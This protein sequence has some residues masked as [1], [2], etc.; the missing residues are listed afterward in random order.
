MTPNNDPSI[1]ISD[2]YVSNDNLTFTVSSANGGNAI[3]TVTLKSDNYADVTLTIP[4]K[5]QDKVTEVKLDPGSGVNSSVQGVEVKGLSE[6]TQNQNTPSGQPVKVMLEMKPVSEPVNASGQTAYQIKT[7][8]DNKVT[9]I[10]NTVNS[11]NT[12]NTKTEYL[13]IKVSKKVGSGSEETIGDVERVLEIAVKYDLT[14]KFNPVVIREHEGAVTAFTAL[15]NRPQEGYRDGTFYIDEDLGII[16]IYSRYFSTFSVA[17]ATVNSFPVTL[18]ANGGTMNLDSQNIVVAEGSMLTLPRP[19]R[20]G[21]DFNGWKEDTN[22]TYQANAS[23]TIAKAT[24]FIVQW[25]PIS[26]GGGSSIPT[27]GGSSYSAPATRDLLPAGG[28]FTFPKPTQR[29]R[30]RNTGNRCI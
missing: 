26:S 23:V 11:G 2:F 28:S 14:G 16:Y 1:G 6:Y 12:N 19:T 15:S 10:F 24:T 13:D 8:I 21:Y 27:G 5:V 30:S 7:A 25:T 9:A 20:S 3:I 18:N 17:C 22:N 29:K 4:V